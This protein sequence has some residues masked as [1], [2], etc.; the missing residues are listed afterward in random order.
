MYCEMLGQSASFGYIYALKL[1]QQGTM[2]NKRVGK[3]HIWDQGLS[4]HSSGSLLRGIARRR[5]LAKIR[6]LLTPWKNY[7]TQRQLIRVSA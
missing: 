4:F 7:V 5:A 1:A 3:Y 6:E 2:V